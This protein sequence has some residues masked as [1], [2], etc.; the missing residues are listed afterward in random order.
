M[1]EQELLRSAYQRWVDGP[2]WASEAVAYVKALE[3]E[4]ERLRTALRKVVAHTG[5]SDAGR[6]KPEL[7]NGLLDS[8]ERIAR[9]A[10]AGEADRAE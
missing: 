8:C 6:L 5:R 7:L 9:A 4:V 3:A 2:D 10:L 1:S